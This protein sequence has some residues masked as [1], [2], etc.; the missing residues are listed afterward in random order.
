MIV[1]VSQ[2]ETFKLPVLGDLAE[3]SVSEQR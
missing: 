1:K 3:K 2:H